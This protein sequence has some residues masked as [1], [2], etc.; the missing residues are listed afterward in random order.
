MIKKNL[1]LTLIIFFIN[2][3]V[4][5]TEKNTNSS[6]VGK[7]GSENY[8]YLIAKNSNYKR[9]K[10]ALKQAKKYYKKEKIEKAK[11]RFNDAIKF[12]TLANKKYPQDPDILNDLGYSLN[13]VDDFMMS[14][15]YY[16][17]GLKID[18]EHIGL[19]A[20]FGKLYVET[21]RID[22]AK[23]RLSS[24]ENCNCDEFEELKSL[25]QKN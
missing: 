11:K 2:N 19:N 1:I 14:E 17:N 22:K 5:S 4:Y 20:N 9:G 18:P 12:F 15:I 23:E 25:I 8:S 24:L 21:N 10:D 3:P 13:R 16:T 7:G 6:E